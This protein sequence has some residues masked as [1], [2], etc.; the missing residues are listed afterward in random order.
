M[1]TLRVM[2][3][4]SEDK[5]AL[6]LKLIVSKVWQETI[7]LKM[8]MNSTLQAHLPS[9]LKQLQSP[10]LKRESRTDCLS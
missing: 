1:A 2:E 4:V 5:L 6:A 9:A 8:M 7:A 3:P 10:R